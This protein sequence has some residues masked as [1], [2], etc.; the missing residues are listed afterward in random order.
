MKHARGEEDLYY[1]SAGPETKKMMKLEQGVNAGDG[2]VVE[3]GWRFESPPG[4]ITCGSRIPLPSLEKE[5]M[6]S[7]SWKSGGRRK[8]ARRSAGEELVVSPLGT[9]GF[10]GLE[11]VSVKGEKRKMKGL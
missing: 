4:P 1:S 8:N 5:R 2:D 3:R 6:W 7:W 11:V 10:W 9:S